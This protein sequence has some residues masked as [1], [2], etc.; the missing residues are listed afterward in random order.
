VQN[1]ERTFYD[2][3]GQVEPPS[4]YARSQTGSVV[5]P[6]SLAACARYAYE[7]TGVPVFVTEHGIATTDDEQRCRL[8]PAALAALSDTI[9]DGIEVVGYT[10]WSLLDNFEWIFGYDPRFGLVEVDRTTFDRT[11]KPSAA[12]Y[13][14]VVR[15]NGV[16]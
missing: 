16:G 10:H 8:V 12:V 3:Q 4:A 7:R 1:Y 9:A 6:E 14:G 2:G 5:E 15:A 13:S 11:P